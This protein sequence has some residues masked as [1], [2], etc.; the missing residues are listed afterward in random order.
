MH[1][2]MMVIS[3]PYVS[4]IQ[5][6]EYIKKGYEIIKVS[7][8]KNEIR[9]IINEVE[10]IYFVER[11]NT[12]NIIETLADMRENLNSRNRDL[13]GYHSYEEMVERMFEL[14]VIHPNLCQIVELGPSQGKLYYDAGN[15]HYEDYNNTIY[16]V[17]LSNNIDIYQDKPNYLFW[18]NIHAREP[19]TAEIC[20]NLIEDLLETY[21]LE[22]DE[23]PLNN[24]QIWIFPVTNPDGRHIVFSG[25]NEM[26]RK[27]IF[28][29]NENGQIDTG[30][31]GASLDGI[32]GNRNFEYMW[33]GSFSYYSETYS[34]TH[35]FSAVEAGYIKDLAAEISF[36]ASLSY[37]S[38]GNEVLY[39]YGYQ[40]YAQSHNYAT[41]SQLAVEL[42][43]RMPI[44]N[45]SNHFSPL[46]SWNSYYAEGSSEDYLHYYH[47]ILAFTIET[48][49][50]F[51]P[52]IDQV[53]FYKE[54]QLEAA[55]YLLTRHQKSFLTGII[56]DQI[57]GE[58]IKAEIKVFPNDLDNPERAPIY[59]DINFG[60]YNYPLVPGEYELLITCENYLPYTANFE[61][62]LTEQTIIN[63]ELTPVI[64]SETDKSS[65]QNIL[66]VKTYP[67]P[68]NPNTNIEFSLSMPSA[69]SIDIFN[70]KGQIVCQI[71]NE[72]LPKGDH[73]YSW[74]G[75][76]MNNTKVSSG[77]YLYQVNTDNEI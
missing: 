49:N 55:Y 71:I 43:D 5:L 50:T 73:K 40:Y 46:P 59:S 27:T 48:A 52:N 61:I 9:L 70:I 62:Y 3:I 20:M 38:Q 23:H 31:G 41:I 26:H 25:R 39:P 4:E 58:P 16:G 18:G 64:I 28:D 44:Y 47:N 65:I 67:N 7:L 17:K 35:P 15:D 6:Y 14:S 63:V 69:I 68:F 66:S 22:N 24:T 42:A 60:R 45:S 57:T 19:L 36:I 34:G 13:L 32:D 11:Y 29:N 56:T 74:N 75:T 37:H 8:A 10:L 51:I 53:E 33:W 54:S 12:V 2:E 30:Y 72:F 1:A 77:V 76:D 21:T